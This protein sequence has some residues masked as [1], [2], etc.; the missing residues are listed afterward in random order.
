MSFIIPKLQKL[1]EEAAPDNRLLELV[2]NFSGDFDEKAGKSNPIALYKPWGYFE[3]LVA[4]CINFHESFGS[5]SPLVLRDG[6]AKLAFGGS[7]VKLMN[8]D[9]NKILVFM[10][11]QMKTPVLKQKPGFIRHLMTQITNDFFHGRLSA[12]VL[13]KSGENLVES[14][15]LEDGVNEERFEEDFISSWKYSTFIRVTDFHIWQPAIKRSPTT[16]TQ[17]ARP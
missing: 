16:I 1:I 5:F 7:P 4:A 2:I 9:D 17:L 6:F 15:L 3:K 10:S 12:A 13:I 8:F 14:Q 11:D